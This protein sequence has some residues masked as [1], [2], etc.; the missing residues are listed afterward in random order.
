MQA[1][2]VEEPAGAC[3][4]GERGTKSPRVVRRCARGIAGLLDSTNVTRDGDRLI[5]PAENS[6][7][8]RP[9]LRPFRTS[10]RLHVHPELHHLVDDNPRSSLSLLMTPAALGGK[11]QFGDQRF[12]RW[13]VALEAYGAAYALQ[14][15]LPIKSGR[16]PRRVK[17]YGRSS[18]ARTSGAPASPSRSRFSEGD[19]VALPDVEVLLPRHRVQPPRKPTTTPFRR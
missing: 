3:I 7:V 2:V 15:L 8:R 13:S 12:V 17:V 1:D 9:L 4:R 19:A 14:D 5:A 10:G 6:A 16:H 18:R 11:A